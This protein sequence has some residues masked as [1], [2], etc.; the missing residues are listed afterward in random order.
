[1]VI[2]PVYHNSPCIMLPPGVLSPSPEMFQKLMS[3]VQMDGLKCP[4]Q[5]IVTLY[6]NLETRVMLKS[7]RLI[8]YLG[9]ALER[10][11][12][13]DLCMHTRVTALIGSTETGEQMS[14]RPANR[15]LWYTHDFL[16]ENG[17]KMI[18]I[19]SASNTNDLHELVLERQ[20]DDANKMFQP[21]FW[22][23]G[24]N[25]IDRIETNELYTPVLDV[26]GR[27]RWVF[28]ARKDDLT[29]LSWLAKF[30]AHDLE[31]RIQQHPDVKGVIVG[32]EGRPAPYVIVE[33]KEGV[34][35]Q[36]SKEQLL[37]SIYAT[38]IAGANDADMKEIRIP[39]ETVFLAKSNKPFRRNLK[40][41]V[42]RKG[43]EEDYREAIKQ[44]YLELEKAQ[45]RV[46]PSP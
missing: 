44:A 18:R 42:M 8:M 33:V 5:T 43:V 22:N 28:A 32:G 24:F 37:E 23:P 6:E 14:I 16:P 27:T 1:M 3:I 41:V 38:V 35:S 7:L 2:A 46:V 12:G 17:S 20:K 15:K 31:A 13:D 21:A 4:P 11:I 26:D 36:K 25:G 40:Q 29:K 9:A 10:S 19:D 34:S 45:L 39:R 30:H